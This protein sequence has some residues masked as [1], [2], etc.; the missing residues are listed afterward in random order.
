MSIQSDSQQDD[1]DMRTK[2]TQDREL[3]EERVLNNA[4]FIASKRDLKVEMSRKNL[5]VYLIISLGCD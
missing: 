5:V 2:L 3:Y 1:I 4:V